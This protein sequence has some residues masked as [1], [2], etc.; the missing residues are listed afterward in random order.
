MINPPQPNLEFKTKN[1]RIIDAGNDGLIVAIDDGRGDDWP[2]AHIEGEEADKLR[3]WRA[4]FAPKML[5]GEK[6]FS[7][8]LDAACGKG[9]TGC[10]HQLALH[11]AVGDMC[12]SHW[13]KGHAL[14]MTADRLRDWLG[15]SM[16][17]YP[18][19]R[20]VLPASG[21]GRKMNAGSGATSSE[22]SLKSDQS[23]SFLKRCLGLFQEEVLVSCYPTLPK[24]GSMQN[25]AVSP[26]PKSAR[27]TSGNDCSSWLTPRVDE[28]GTTTERFRERMIERGARA[29]QFSDLRHQVEAETKP[30]MFPTPRAEDAESCGGHNTRQVADSLRA[31]VTWPTPA[32]ANY[33]D[34]KASPETMARNSRPLQEVVISGPQAPD[35]PNTT[36]KNPGLWLTPHGFMGQEKDGA[37]GGGGEFAKQVNQWGSPRVTTNGG[38]AS[39]QCTGKGSRLEDQAGRRKQKLNPDW[40]EQLMNVPVGWTN[41]LSGSID[42][43]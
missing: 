36:G 6:P 3:A 29:H 16:P 35:S 14:P 30:T 4:Q 13:R 8:Q 22:S 23:T 26:R 43:G 20:G 10:G 5:V 19:S 1:L 25:G 15:L 17:E 28:D 40:C 37:Y 12:I 9:R 24:Q 7:S 21:K 41:V 18:A 34:G 39:P 38:S 32:A 31:A 42:S 11:L 27:P 33:R 2:A